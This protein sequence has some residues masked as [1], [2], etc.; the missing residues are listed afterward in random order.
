VYKLQIQIKGVSPLLFNGWT[1]RAK[2]SLEGPGKR[3]GKQT[4]VD[5]RAEAEEK[6]YRNEEGN[7]IIPGYML[8]SAVVKGAGM[9]NLKSNRRGLGSYLKG[10][11]FVEDADL[12][13]DTVD[14]NDER[15]IPT[16]SGAD[17]QVRP[18]FNR[19][20]E[21]TAIVSVVDDAISPDDIRTAIE[22]AGMYCAVGSHRPDFGRFTL[23][24]I[25]L[26]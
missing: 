24:K 25:E 1:Q 22:T 16:K 3:G 13:T 6:A 15:I 26:V 12:G 11:M 20:W 7:F 17:I 2:E 5:K 9:A 8:K 10:A 21:A 23:E 18:A 4:I 14:Y 19:D